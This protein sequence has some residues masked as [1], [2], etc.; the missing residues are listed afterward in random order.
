MRHYE[1]TFI[2]DPVLPGD[3]IKSA[4]DMYIKQLQVEGCEIVHVLEWGTRLM[5]YPINK[6]ANGAYFTVEV[7]SPSGDFIKKIEIA[8]NRDE[9]ILR[10]LTVSLD[11]YAVQYNKDRRAGLIG[12]K[13]KVEGEGETEE[14]APAAVAP[15]APAP[16][17]PAPKPAVVEAPV[18]PA[19]VVEA[20]APVVAAPVVEAVAPEAPAPVVEAVAPVVEAPVEPEPVAEAEPE[21][22]VVE[23]VEPVAEAVVEAAEPVVEAVAETVETVE[24]AVESHV[25]AEPVVETPTDENA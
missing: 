16:V 13:K 15:V 8:F 23:N 10:F 5:A 22:V 21:D 19:P 17:A 24:E 2:V 12:K 4:A 7:S 6:R 14:Q 18:A 25:A 1:I 9:R 11:K 20:V 3:E